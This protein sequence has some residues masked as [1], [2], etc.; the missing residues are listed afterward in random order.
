MRTA[1]YL[2]ARVEDQMEA[3]FRD[4]L[5]LCSQMNWEVVE[6]YSESIDKDG[7]EN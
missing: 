4:F 1:G 2:R 5:E 6:T 7:D 3:L